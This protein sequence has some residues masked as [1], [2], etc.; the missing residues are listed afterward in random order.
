[1]SLNT[2]QYGMPMGS[3]TGASGGGGTTVGGAISFDWLEALAIRWVGGE[4]EGMKDWLLMFCSFLGR[5]ANQSSADRPK[6]SRHDIR[7]DM[8]IR[9]EAG[10]HRYR[11]LSPINLKSSPGSARLRLSPKSILYPDYPW[12]WVSG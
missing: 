6:R 2:L 12:A 7:R 5:W 4:V 8:A 3:V 9:G 1:M 10:D 11:T